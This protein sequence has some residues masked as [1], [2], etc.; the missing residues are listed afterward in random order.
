M[1]LHKTAANHPAKNIPNNPPEKNRSEAVRSGSPASKKTSHNI[2]HT[3]TQK[4]QGLRKHGGN[5]YKKLSSRRAL[6]LLNLPDSKADLKI[7]D[8]NRLNEKMTKILS[9][10]VADIEATK[11]KLLSLNQGSLSKT[12]KEAIADTIRNLDIIKSLKDSKKKGNKEF[13][14]HLAIASGYI[15]QKIKFPLENVTLETIETFGESK[16]AAAHM[17]CWL[18]HAA[19]SVGKLDGSDGFEDT[20]K[21]IAIKLKVLSKETNSI[22]KKINKIQQKNV[23]K[24]VPWVLTVGIPRN[25]AEKKAKQQ[26]VQ[27]TLRFGLDSPICKEL[28]LTQDIKKA[29]DNLK[30]IDPEKQSSTFFTTGYY[31]TENLK[32]WSQ[33]EELAGFITSRKTRGDRIHYRAKNQHFKIVRW[34][35][36]KLDGIANRTLANPCMDS[37]LSHHEGLAVAKAIDICDEKFDNLLENKLTQLNSKSAEYA[38]LKKLKNVRDRLKGINFSNKGSHDEIKKAWWMDNIIVFSKLHPRVANWGVLGVGSESSFFINW[39]RKT[40]NELERL[41]LDEAEKEQEQATSSPSVTETKPN[42]EEHKKKL[43][44]D[45]RNDLSEKCKKNIL[46]TKDKLGD[47]RYYYGNSFKKEVMGFEEKERYDGP[48]TIEIYQERITTLTKFLGDE[49]EQWY[50]QA[51]YWVKTLGKDIESIAKQYFGM[52]LDLKTNDQSLTDEQLQKKQILIEKIGIWAENIIQFC[53]NKYT[54]TAKKRDEISRLEDE[55]KKN[56]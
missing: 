50:W 17:L 55:I 47:F 39:L 26:W 46:E 20:P 42:P 9:I 6:Q 21:N 53:S 19:F 32:N 28:H 4:T 22:L 24:G 3:P 44:D 14:Q 1:N 23:H 10:D 25:N 37:N 40:F 18:E 52:T 48:D 29:L 8:Y 2:T 12:E 16:K 36:R 31:D 27:D 5:K 56:A 33:A 13:A 54:C 41:T 35:M 7:R 49:H 38:K 45:E 15:S 11:T 43:S 34:L 30:S 51:Q